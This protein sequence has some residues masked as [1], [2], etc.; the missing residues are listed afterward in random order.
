M[1]LINSISLFIGI[2]VAIYGIESWRREYKGK[3][4]IDLAEE[5][6]SLFYEAKDVIAY[7]RH[8]FSNAHETEDIER[9]NGESEAEYNARKNASVVFKRYNMHIELFNKIYSMRYRFMAHF[10]KDKEKPFEELNYIVREITVAA[11]ML[12]R[13]WPIGTF[14]TNEDFEKHQKR[15]EK[16][17]G[18]F[19]AGANEEDPINPK[20]EKI[21]DEI[22]KYCER[23]IEAKGSLYYLLNY[24]LFKK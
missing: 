22:E 24:K 19:W 14:T 20:V 2:W 23:I 13:L 3:K 11:R 5:T 7:I 15:I 9:I 4:E 16:Y 8:P 10:G 18:V 12:S 1:E 17:E 6:L 21:V